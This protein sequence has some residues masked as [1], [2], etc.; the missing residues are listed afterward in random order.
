[1]GKRGAASHV[2]RGLKLQL[3]AKEIGLGDSGDWYATSF[4]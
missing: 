4:A 1:M 2:L 3:S